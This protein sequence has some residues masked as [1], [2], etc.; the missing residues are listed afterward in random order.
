MVLNNEPNY[1]NGRRYVLKLHRDAVPGRMSGRLENMSTGRHYE[2]DTAEA[3][4]AGLALDLAA[5]ES[6][7]ATFSVF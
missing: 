1:P 3:L 4:L 7:S 5:S 6:E 2:F